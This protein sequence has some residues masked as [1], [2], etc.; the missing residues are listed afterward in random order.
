MSRRRSN[1]GTEDVGG[2]QV[3]STAYRGVGLPVALYVQRGS[4]GRG[5]QERILRPGRRAQ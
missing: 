4:S 5:A 2:Q 3:K 1:L